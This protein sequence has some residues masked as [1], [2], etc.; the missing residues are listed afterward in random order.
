MYSHNQIRPKGAEKQLSKI[1]VG[2]GGMPT[3]AVT[4]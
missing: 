3:I 2:G 1:K 4:V